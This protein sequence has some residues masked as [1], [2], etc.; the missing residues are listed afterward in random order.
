VF[1]ADTLTDPFAVATK[2][3]TDGE[4]I[5]PDGRIVRF[6]EEQ[7]TDTSIN[8]F[9]CWG[10]VKYVASP[11]DRDGNR[12]GR[13]AEFDDLAEKILTD[14]GDTYWWQ[15]TLE[16]WGI[17]ASQWHASESLRESNRAEVRNLL[18]YGFRL[19]TL[20][21]FTIC[22]CCSTEK[23]D[24]WASVGGVEPS[25]N[26]DDLALQVYDLFDQIDYPKS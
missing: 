16:L 15:P 7:D 6:R 1:R 10:R 8:D 17:P 24:G 3:V 11:Y 13:P 14:R 19:L 4:A 5:L 22:P 25:S 9:E 21:T 2:L 26:N 20:E 12:A 23:L 18:N